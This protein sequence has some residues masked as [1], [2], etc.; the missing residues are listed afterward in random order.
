[1]RNLLVRRQFNGLRF[2]WCVPLALAAATIELQSQAVAQP[3]MK[4]IKY[5]DHKQ[6]R[7]SVENM[8]RS[9]AEIPPREQAKFDQYFTQYILPP[10]AKA[11]KPDGPVDLPEVRNEIKRNFRLANGA[12]YEQL[13]RIV[14]DFMKHVVIHVK[15]PACRVNA[16]IVLGDLNESEGSGAR[17][18]KPLPGALQDLVSY[19]KMKNLPDYM[20]VVCM[21]GVQRHASMNDTYP[22]APEVKEDITRLMLQ[23]LAETKA[24]DTR[25]PSGH[26]YMRRSAAEILG[27]LGDI[28][29]NGEILTAVLDAMNEKDAPLSFRL[30]LC[31]VV[32]SFVYP[33]KAKVDYKKAIIAV[34]APVIDASERELAR[35]LQLAEQQQRFVAPDRRRLGYVFKQA[36]LALLGTPRSGKVGLVGAATAAADPLAATLGG[37]GSIVR[38][39]LSDL[40]K[41]GLEID[42][43]EFEDKL[44]N[45]KQALP[46]SAV[47][48][49]LPAD[50]GGKKVADRAQK[51]VAAIP[52]N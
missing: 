10:I 26:A 46:K 33:P 20:R 25:A 13:T 8:L 11:D 50:A 2:L 40:D 41:E 45:I 16:L 39:T 35:A 47:N 5:V 31:G 17:P 38:K 21:V 18:A 19:L 6:D 12:A 51:K 34:F 52:A 48:G 28:G 9:G 29:K 49:K 27:G 44:A 3:P 43:V 36:S 15:D 32:G 7:F 24:P 1:M 14:R 30:G 37:L 22:V 42:P 23:M 4:A